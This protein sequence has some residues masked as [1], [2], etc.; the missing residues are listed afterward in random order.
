MSNKNNTVFGYG[1]GIDW[2]DE[3]TIL[4][5]MKSD[6]ME[7]FI[8]R[9]LNSSIKHRELAKKISRDE[10]LIELFYNDA[11]GVA[12]EFTNMLNEYLFKLF[13]DAK[14]GLRFEVNREDYFLILFHHEE[15][16]VA[17]GMTIIE[18]EKVVEALAR[19]IF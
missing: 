4:S 7:S 11:L 19:S 2:N 8:K 1:V 9:S 6:E 14:H 18:K 12:E 15:Y 13:P 3:E 10:L 5:L 16:E 17:P